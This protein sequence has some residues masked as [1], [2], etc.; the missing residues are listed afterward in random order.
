MLELNIIY[1]RLST[2]RSQRPPVARVL[3]GRKAFDDSQERRLLQSN[4]ADALER[5]SRAAVRQPSRHRRSLFRVVHCRDVEHDDAEREE[6]R[7]KAG[8]RR[9]R[10]N[11]RWRQK[12]K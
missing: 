7:A 1:F 11:R 2:R 6:G 8:K 12:A 4:D 5:R 3:F 10:R 9:N